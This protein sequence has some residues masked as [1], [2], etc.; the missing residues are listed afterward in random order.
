MHTLKVLVAPAV[1]NNL[2][3]FLKKIRLDISCELSAHRQ[4]TW[5][6]KSYFLHEIKKIYMYILE[7]CL[8]QFWMAL[9]GLILYVVFDWLVLFYFQKGNQKLS[10]VCMVL[11]GGAWLF[12]AISLVVTLCKKIT[13]LT[14]LYYFSYIKLGV[15]LIKYVPQVRNSYYISC[16]INLTWC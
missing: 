2:F 12:A 10:K 6:A 3:F 15:T 1:E 8:L 7:C 9:K 14:Y 4:F 11:V 13:W 5:N 16:Q